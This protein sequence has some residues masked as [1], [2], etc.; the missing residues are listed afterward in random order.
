FVVILISV[1]P[2]KAQAAHAKVQYYSN[3]P[4]ADKISVNL[5]QLES[6]ARTKGVSLAAA[7]ANTV[8]TTASGGVALDIVTSHL[9]PDVE[10]KLRIPGVTVRHISEKYNRASVVISDP[11]LLY[12]LASIPEV[13][14]IRPEYGAITHVGAVTSRADVALKA[15]QAKASF[16]VDGSGQ[17]IGILS[18]SFACAGNRDANTLP[19]AG[20]AGTLTG[21]PSQDSGDLP[22]AVTLL[23]D[24]STG[25]SDEGAGMAELAYDIAPGAAIAFASAFLGEAAFAQGITDLC[26]PPVNSTVVVDD[27]LYFTEPM[28]QDGIVAQAAAACV[29][30]GVPYFSS[31]GNN[32]NRGFRQG[33]VD[34][35]VV[36]D[37]SFPAS[38]NDLHDWGVGDG[39]LDVINLPDGAN[40]TVTLQ[41]N[42]P[43]DSVSAG[44]G[45]Q[46]DLD[47]HITP[48][49]DV[50]GL[51]APLAVSFS[52]QGITGAPAGDAVEIASYTNTTGALQTVYIAVEHFDGN[53]GVIPQNAATPVEFRLVFSEKGGTA[54]I[55]GITDETSAFGGPTI[56]GHA[57]AIGATSV[58]AVPWYDSALYDPNFLP[59]S[60]TDPEGFTAR[61]GSLPIQFGTDG[62]FAPRASFEPDIAAVDGNN[63]SFFGGDINLGGP[64]GEPDGF[65]NFFG[66]SAAAPNAA[67]V[68]ALMRHADGALTPLAINTTLENT[69]ID[70]TGFRAAIGSDDVTGIGLVDALAAV[71]SLTPPLNQPPVADA[72]ADQNTHAGALVTLD[73][74][75]S[76]DPN[77]AIA[78]YAWSQTAGI[79]VT[80]VRE[81]TATPSFTAPGSATVL[82]FDLTV[83][84]HGGLTALSSVNVTIAAPS[85]GGGGGGGCLIPSGVQSGCMLAVLG[86]MIGGVA[87][88]RRRIN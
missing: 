22:A 6:Q 68:A 71:A 57:M 66:T 25:C 77:G 56:Y 31:A 41:W 67:A 48:T 39:F 83:A 24:L 70:I 16:A 44:A 17:K 43:F 50:A 32:A 61:G 53:Q 81:S 15:D 8:F 13:R 58:A 59:T 51:A 23:S 33:F 55:Q 54:L 27:V 86:L 87:L 35:N 10:R 21:S 46:I 20:A 34:I 84:D 49:P 18:D 52:A 80:L 88:A 2:Q 60:A 12:Q 40:I 37:T 36:D 7:A 47:L 42:Q 14:S 64:F 19:A 65:P 3:A 9:G 74:S 4:Q 38:G 82:T 62:T 79:P 78:S 30:S 63:T 73:G 1:A 75:S 11:A 5:L 26:S 69:A 72:G 45:A 29:A 76:S 85:G 28:Y